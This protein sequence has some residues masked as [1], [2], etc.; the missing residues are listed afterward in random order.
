MCLPFDPLS[1]HLVLLWG[2][3][4]LDDTFLRYGWSCKYIYTVEHTSQVHC[5]TLYCLL[6]YTTFTA[7]FLITVYVLQYICRNVRLDCIVGCWT[8]I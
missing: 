2:N 3:P 7:E 1:P 8:A 4:V 6:V 5:Y